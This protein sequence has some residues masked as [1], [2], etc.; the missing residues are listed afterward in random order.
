[1][2]GEAGGGRAGRGRGRG[3]RS[4]RR[5]P[6]RRGTRHPVSSS[7]SSSSSSPPVLDYYSI[8]DQTWVK[9]RDDDVSSSELGPTSKDLSK[10][11]ALSLDDSQHASGSTD[12][13][14]LDSTFAQPA[15]LE[16][17][18]SPSLSEEIREYEEY[19][20][21]HTFDSM[22]AAFEYLRTGQRVVLPKVEFSDD[23]S[24]SE[25][26][27][28]EKSE[29]QSTLEPEHDKS[30]VTQGQCDDSSLEGITQNG[31]KWMSEEAM[32]A[33]E[34]YITRRDDLKEYDYQFDELLHQCFN[35]EHYYKIFHHFNFT[36][37]MKA[38]CSTDWTS[39]LYFAEVKE[40]LGH[41]IYFCSPL[42]PNEDGNCYAC[43]NQGMENLKHPIVGV[44]DRGFP[45]QVFPYTY[46]S[47]SEDEA[48]L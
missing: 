42:E 27:L 32:V 13:D 12:C 25:Q 44:F 4:T 11:E 38:P 17:A 46:S 8:H 31:K 6:G 28:L 16:E 7:S 40:L 47:G 2:D 30:A 24:S 35:V 39:V 41:K 19:L 3:D 37:K 18:V 9:E 26:F 43:K 34:K 5:R 33:F 23:E 36:V 29:D 22:E 10:V 14:G 15:A 21:E 48:W 45:T 20:K 1:M